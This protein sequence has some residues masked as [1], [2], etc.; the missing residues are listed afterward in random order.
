[1]RP[2]GRERHQ[3]LVAPRPAGSEL[4]CAEPFATLFLYLSDQ[5]LVPGLFVPA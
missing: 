2:L 4:G 1:L 5:R 3:A